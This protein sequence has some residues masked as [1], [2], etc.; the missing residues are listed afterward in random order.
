MREVACHSSIWNASERFEEEIG[1]DVDFGWSARESKWTANERQAVGNSVVCRRDRTSSFQIE[2]PNKVQWYQ[3]PFRLF[4]QGSGDWRSISWRRVE[5]WFSPKGPKKLHRRTTDPTPSWRDGHRDKMGRA[6]VIMVRLKLSG[7]PRRRLRIAKHMLPPRAKP[8]SQRSWA[9]AAFA[10]RQHSMS[11]PTHLCTRSRTGA[12]ASQG[13]AM[14][15]RE[16]VP[17]TSRLKHR[18]GSLG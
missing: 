4:M 5:M 7:I 13:R 8:Q 12:S 11:H 9:R 18:L 1:E 10:S 14:L 15:D 16:E 6:F 17:L 2:K 3:R